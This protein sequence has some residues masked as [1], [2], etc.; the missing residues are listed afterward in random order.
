MF[1][2]KE[3]IFD[4]LTVVQNNRTVMRSM[5]IA[6]KISYHLHKTTTTQLYMEGGGDYPLKLTCRTIQVC[7]WHH[8]VSAELFQKGL[9]HRF[10]FI[11]EPS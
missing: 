6:N 2:G 9:A 3:L 8:I 10:P 7:F 5:Q 4:L 11:Y 1:V